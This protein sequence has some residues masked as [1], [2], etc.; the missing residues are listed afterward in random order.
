MDEAVKLGVF[1][2]CLKREIRFFIISS[3]AQ[4]FDL[5]YKK[6]MRSAANNLKKAVKKFS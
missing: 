3:I 1:K 2:N 6:F 4:V 5:F